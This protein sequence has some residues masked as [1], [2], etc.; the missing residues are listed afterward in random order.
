MGEQRL[1]LEQKKVEAV[2]LSRFT[3][4]CYQCATCSGVCPKA[5]VKKGFLLR[6]IIFNAVTGHAERIGSAA[7][8]CLTCGLCQLRCPMK[9]DIL[10]TIRQARVL[11]LRKMNGEASN[12]FAHDNTLGTSL[13]NIMKSPSVQPRKKQFLA[14]D[15]RTSDA[16]DV[17]YYV[18]CVPFFDIVF[19]D[20]VGYEGM[21]I[22]DNSLRLMNLVGVEPAVLDNEKC[23]GHDQLWRG[24]EGVFREFAKQNAEML[25]KFKTIVVSCPECY[26][27]LAVDYK[28]RLG[29]NL[30]VKHI[31]EF[32][33]PHADKLEALAKQKNI[34]KPLITFHDSCRLGKHMRIHEPPRELL[35]RV[36]Y[37]IKEMQ[38]NREESLCCGVPQFV[39]C[40]D[41]N[42]EIRRRKLNDAIETGAKIMVSPCGKCQVHLKCL[43]VDK[44]EAAA[45]RKY[46]LAIKDFSTML[47]EAI[48]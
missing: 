43:Q 6:Q 17:L 47:M 34:C 31:S 23:C 2:D 26:R 27:T 3:A 13:Y 5:R 11:S 20:D 38:R 24:Q 41:E 37:E 21:A 25:K 29:I 18:G 8:D 12:L 36:G 32:L 46:D 22:V 45:G 7:W 9:V 48:K 35:R 14:S 16:S 44:G 39:S 33:L 10:E 28:E 40:D 19:K 15:V 42:K 4:L 30:N 1:V